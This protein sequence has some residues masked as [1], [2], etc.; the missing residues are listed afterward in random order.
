MHRRPAGKQHGG[1]WEFP[2]GKVEPG[3]TLRQALVR[4]AEEELGI[5]LDACDLHAAALADDPDRT[6]VVI[7]LY[8]CT[9]WQGE[10]QSREG[11]AVAWC[12][13]DTMRALPKPPLDRALVERLICFSGH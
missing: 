1:L 6:P 10:P 4:E 13:A 11:G 12:D 3:E 5:G 2:G 8:S 7:L 9:R